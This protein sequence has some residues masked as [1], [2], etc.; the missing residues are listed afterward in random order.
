M[1]NFLHQKY[2][3]VGVHEICLKHLTVRFFSIYENQGRLTFV[4]IKASNFYAK[5]THR[6]KKKHFDSNEIP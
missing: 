3:K 2:Y 4:K 1:E 6:M 5:Q